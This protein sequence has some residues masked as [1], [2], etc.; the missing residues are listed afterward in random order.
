MATRGR[1]PKPSQVKELEG[2]PGKRRIN[3][4]EPKPAVAETA[5][6]YGVTLTARRFHRRYAPLLKTLGILTEADG[7]AFEM[8]AIHYGIA[9]DAAQELRKS[10]LT[11]EGRD[12]PKKNPL[13]QIV[14]DNS[15][16]FRGYAAE[17][18]MTPSARSRLAVGEADQMSLADIL[19]GMATEVAEDASS[20]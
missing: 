3:H 10:T 9:I 7:A 12:G 18:G 20:A 19:F 1:K 13:V 16:A 8:M 14:R 5:L 6:T 4:S 17:F 11:T 15:A 2:N